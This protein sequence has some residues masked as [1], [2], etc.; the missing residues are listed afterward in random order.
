MA[1]GQGVVSLGEIGQLG[2]R[3][4]GVGANCLDSGPHSVLLK[5]SVS[6]KGSVAQGQSLP[7]LMVIFL[8]SLNMYSS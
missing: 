2:K 6:L 3:N 4:K 7:S 5:G 1:H 8:V